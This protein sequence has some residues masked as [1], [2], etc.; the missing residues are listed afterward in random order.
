MYFRYLHTDCTMDIYESIFYQ[1]KIKS[2]TNMS[3]GSG[4]LENIPHFTPPTPHQDA[5]RGWRQGSPAGVRGW[6]V[7]GAVGQLPH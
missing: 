4:F 2:S 1:K 3:P 5:E 6:A 7:S